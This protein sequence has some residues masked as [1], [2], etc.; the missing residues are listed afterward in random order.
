MSL[1]HGTIVDDQS[2]VQSQNYDFE[3]NEFS[4]NNSF[5]LKRLRSRLQFDWNLDESFVNRIINAVENSECLENDLGKE[6]Y[7]NIVTLIRPFSRNS[8][9]FK[10]CTETVVINATEGRRRRGAFT[11]SKSTTLLFNYYLCCSRIVDIGIVITDVWR[12]SE[13]E[14]VKVNCEVFKKN[15]VCTVFI[16]KCE[17]EFYPLMVV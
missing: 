9:P 8:N 15:N 6:K 1:L 16:L 11:F 3:K 4:N 2:L 10:S 17:Q 7:S 14:R 13:F 5:Y 12:P